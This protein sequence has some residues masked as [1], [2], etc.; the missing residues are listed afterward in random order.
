VCWDWFDKSKRATAPPASS[1]SFFSIFIPSLLVRAFT[2]IASRL[3]SHL[4][5]FL[6][7]L[8]SDGLT[9]GESI[10][11]PSFPWRNMVSG[12][13]EGL[14]NPYAT[15]YI[16]GGEGPD[17]NLRFTSLNLFQSP[18][19]SSLASPL[20]SNPGG[21][22]CVI[23]SIIVPATASI[24][25]SQYPTCLSTYSQLATNASRLVNESL[26]GKSWQ[27]PSTGLLGNPFLCSV[28]SPLIWT[29]CPLNPAWPWTASRPRSPHRHHNKRPS[30]NNTNR[31]IGP[32]S[33]T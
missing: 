6:H 21:T 30:D 28:T 15:P 13:G 12:P 31:L 33:N 7:I 20:Q 17:S 22:G 18:N 5:I 24:Q 4:V 25:Q 23:A 8:S 1:R 9:R 29:S 26:T 2:S 16:R 10:A 14:A 27:S 32:N 19:A 3:P 11:L